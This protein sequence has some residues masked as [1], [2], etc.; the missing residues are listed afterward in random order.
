[1]GMQ[2]IEIGTSVRLTKTWGMNDI[3]LDTDTGEY[4]LGNMDFLGGIPLGGSSIVDNGNGTYTVTPPGN[5][6]PFT[7]TTLPGVSSDPNNALV[8]GGDGLPFL[9]ADNLIELGTTVDDQTG[10]NAGAAPLNPPA[11]PDAGDVHVENYDD[12]TVWWVYDG[13]NWVAGLNLAMTVVPQVLMSNLG[14]TPA[15][16]VF[17]G[18]YDDAG[19]P[20]LAPGYEFAV[21]VFDEANSGQYRALPSFPYQVMPLMIGAAAATD[22]QLGAVPQPVAGEEGYFLRGDA[23][24]QPIVSDSIY[25]NDGNLAGNRTLTGTTAFPGFFASLAFEQLG[26]FSVETFGGAGQ[27]SDFRVNS[28]GSWLRRDDGARN[29][30]VDILGTGTSLFWNAPTNIGMDQAVNLNSDGIDLVHGINSD[31]RLNGDP[32]TALQVITSNGPGAPATWETI[33]FPVGPKSVDRT[34]GVDANNWTAVAGGFTASVTAAQHTAGA[35]VSASV[36]NITTGELVNES[37]D[38]IS[39]DAAGN[40]TIFAAAPTAIRVIATPYTV[41]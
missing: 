19:Q 36:Y 8:V 27:D 25:A 9:D 1:M 29:N 24:W 7:F 14:G 23:T 6:T 31:L 2:N 10:N 15:N 21:P 11:A 20:S 16:S 30:G 41:A 22:G 17:A 33:T 13:T 5:G 37:F 26:G 38:T 40:I 3:I 28:L 12:T 35:L 18:D 34:A 4:F 39:V 32:G